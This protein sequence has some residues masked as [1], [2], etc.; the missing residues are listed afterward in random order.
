MEADEAER[1]AAEEAARAAAP[2]PGPHAELS[3]CGLSFGCAAGESASAAVLLH[4]RGTA[5]VRWRWERRG[6]PQHPFAVT[7]VAEPPRFVCSKRV[8]ADG[9]HVP[10]KR[11]VLAVHS[12][13]MLG[14]WPVVRPPKV[15][16]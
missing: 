5:A 9:R 4:S 2:L 8:S 13:K 3:S 16:A 14:R 15:Q 11:H 12:Y 10:H 6:V 7:E 1:R